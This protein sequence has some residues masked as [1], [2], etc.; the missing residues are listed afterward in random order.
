MPTPPRYAL[1]RV[2]T[3]Q[4][5]ERWARDLPFPREIAWTPRL[6]QSTNDLTIVIDHNEAWLAGQ[7]LDIHANLFIDETGSAVAL[8]L[9]D[10]PYLPAYPDLSVIGYGVYTTALG[11]P[12]TLTAEWDNTN[13]R[14]RFIREGAAL[15][16]ATASGAQLSFHLRYRSN[17]KDL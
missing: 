14:V 11:T 15:A 16:F 10:L 1:S 12:Y 3:L 6:R 2:H 13:S 17:I 8:Y 5:I 7:W 4:D 9:H